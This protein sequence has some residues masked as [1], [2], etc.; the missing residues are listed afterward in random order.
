MIHLAFN[1]LHLFPA[2]D[3]NRA[4]PFSV[5]KPLQ[6]ISPPEKQKER[7]NKKV[8]KQVDSRGNEKCGD[9]IKEEHGNQNIHRK[10]LRQKLRKLFLEKQGVLFIE[11]RDEEDERPYRKQD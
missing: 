9:K 3:D 7:R 4:L 10:R 11:T 6:P 1:L 8:D 5:H 2:P